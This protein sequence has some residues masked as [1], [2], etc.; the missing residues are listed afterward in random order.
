[1]RMDNQEQDNASNGLK[2]LWTDSEDDVLVDCLVQLKV[3]GRFVVDIGFGGGYVGKLE[4]M[5]KEKIPV[6]NIKAHPSIWS[7][8]R[9]LKHQWQIVHNMIYDANT[10][11]FG[12]DPVNKCIK[13]EDAVWEQYVK[14]N[15]NAGK[16]CN[17]KLRHFEKLAFI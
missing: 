14:G 6:T 3:K 8:L 12:R 10:S 1:M 4:E 11:G 13:A 17:R 9:T 5:L 16:F 7:R 2:H 15:K